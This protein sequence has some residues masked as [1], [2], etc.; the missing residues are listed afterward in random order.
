MMP[1]PGFTAMATISRRSTDTS[2]GSNLMSFGNAIRIPVNPSTHISQNSTE[3]E[4]PLPPAQPKSA[5]FCN[6][7]QQTQDIMKVALST[8]S[9]KTVHETLA[10]KFP[11]RP[12]GCVAVAC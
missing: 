8:D 10:E 9:I 4:P 6:V 5:R 2:N 11:L 7:L 12:L 1:A 3:N